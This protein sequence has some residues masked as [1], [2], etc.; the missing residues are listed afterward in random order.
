LT[1]L[2]RLRGYLRPY[3]GSLS[4]MATAA[5]TGVFVSISIPLVTKA[6]IDTK[7]PVTAAAAMML[8]DPAYGRR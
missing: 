7:T 5:I 4:I 2:W 1:S 6:I 3:V 8:S